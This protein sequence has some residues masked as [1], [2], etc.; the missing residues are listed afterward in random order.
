MTAY[1]IEQFDLT[2]FNGSAA[3]FIVQGAFQELNVTTGMRESP[4]T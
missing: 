2:P 1:L 4:T 3:G